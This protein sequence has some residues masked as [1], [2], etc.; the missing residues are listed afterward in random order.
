MIRAMPLLLALAAASPAA[1]AERRLPVDDF[2]R[3]IVEGPYVVH[4]I[5]GRASAASASGSREAL[6]RLSLDVQGQ[7]LRIRR[8]RSGWVG[9][10][11]TDSGTVTIELATRNL[12]SARL[13]G[14]ARLEAENV[15]GL[16]VEFSVEGSGSLRAA[17]VDA[18]NLSLALLGSGRLEIAGVARVLRGDFQGTG[19]VAAAALRAGNATVTTTT[20]GAIALT[21]NGPVTITANGLAEVRILGRPDC[22]IRGIAAD[23]VR[24]GGSDQ[25]QIR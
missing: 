14:P 18:D 5:T 15:H 22:T 16:N 3:V 12:R 2:D 19:E 21:V 10:P 25:R 8:S 20:S 23:Q 24:C 11:G 1:A 4:L 9:S 17:G 6:D 13:V 7:T